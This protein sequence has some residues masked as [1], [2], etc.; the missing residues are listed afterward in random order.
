MIETDMHVVLPW[1]V[2]LVF[3]SALCAIVSSAH[4]AARPSLARLQ[5]RQRSMLLLALALLPPAVAALVAVLGFAPVIGGLIVDRHCHPATG[6]VAHVPALNAGAAYATALGVVLAAAT[7]FVLLRICTRLRRTVRLANTLASVAEP[8]QWQRFDIIDSPMELAYCVGLLRPKVLLSRGLVERLP[9]AQLHAIL[10][11]EHAHVARRDN[12][13]HWLAMVSLL[14][15][16]RARRRR[17]LEDLVLAS[18]QACD[19][20]AA[21]QAGGAIA[22]IEALTALRPAQAPS[23]IRTAVTFG[24]EATVASRIRALEMLPGRALDPA[25][26]AALIVTVYAAATVVA[27]YFAHHGTELVLGWLT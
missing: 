2:F 7:G 6:C 8:S 18:E 9:P 4:V 13:R 20:E 1:L 10:R 15:L 22:V 23:P 14:P 25:H 26:I 24:R 5:P 21:D 27:T 17:V 16:P 3:W 19:R 11:H 12:L